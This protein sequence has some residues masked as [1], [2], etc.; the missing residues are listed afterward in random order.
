M[1]GSLAAFSMTVLP[2]AKTALS[3]GMDIAALHLH[4]STH[5]GE[6][7]DVLVDGADAEVAAAGHGHIRLAEAAQQSADEIVGGPDPMRQVIGGPGAVD[8]TAVNLH[9]VAVDGADVGTQLL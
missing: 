6:A 1:W 4:G 7:L 8:M 9:R 3:I 5:G 2:S